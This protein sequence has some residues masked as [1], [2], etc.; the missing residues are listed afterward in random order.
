MTQYLRTF[1]AIELPTSVKN[2]IIDHIQSYRELSRSSIKWVDPENLHITLKFMGEF[3]RSHVT[4]L[5]DLLIDRLKGV[6][7]FKIHIDHMGAFPNLHT[8]KVIWLGIDHLENLRLIFRDI[9]DCIVRLGYKADD[10]PFSPHLTIGRI[11]RDLSSAEI[12]NI[13]QRLSNSDT[14][15]QAE[16][17]VESVVFFK[18]ELTREGPLYSKLFEVHLGK[19][20]SLC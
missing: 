2:K 9:E 18:S 4:N 14:S 15:F 12:K 16:F 20:S 13:G 3:D 1:L 7:V 17:P 10:R 5:H 6:L 11:R 19:S 8:P